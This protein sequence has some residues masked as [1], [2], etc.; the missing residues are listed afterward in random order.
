MEPLTPE[1]RAV[2]EAQSDYFVSVLLRRYGL[3]E[4]DLPQILESLRWMRDHR[5]FMQRLQT[6]G[7]MSLIALLATAIGSA[8]WQGIRTLL[9]GGGQ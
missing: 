4:S 7:T 8:L 2:A 5:A 9:G 1:Q 6:G 3:N